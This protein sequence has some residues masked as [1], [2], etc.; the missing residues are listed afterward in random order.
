M[1]RKQVEL[2]LGT[3]A[4][5]PTVQR[6]GQ[7][8]VAVQ[9]TPKTNS[10]LQL[11]QALRYTPQVLGQANN[12][13]KSMG[14]EAA[15]QVADVEAALQDEEVKGI[16]GYDKAYQQGLVKR[17]FS[18]NESAIR[19]RFMDLASSPEYMAMDPNEFVAAMQAERAK[20]TGELMDDFGGNANREDT[21]TA[22]SN[23]F[24][25]GLIDDA[26]VK[27]LENKNNEV[28]INASAEAQKVMSNPDKSLSEAMDNLRGELGS[29]GMDFK[30]V[31]AEMR[32]ALQSAVLLAAEEGKFEQADQLVSQAEKYLVT[33]KAS[34]LGSAEGKRLKANLLNTIEQGRRRA[35]RVKE[36]SG[37]DF[38][39]IA[40]VAIGGLNKLSTK[41]NVTPSQKRAIKDAIS[42]LSPNGDIDELYEKVWTGIGFPQQN[43]GSLLQELGVNG[44]DAAREAYYDSAASIAKKLEFIQNTPI[45]PISLTPEYKQ[46]KIEEFKQYALNNTESVTAEDWVKAT[47]QPF[48]PFEELNE[49]SNELEKGDFIRKTNEYTGI[50]SQLSNAASKIEDDAQ[51]SDFSLNE[52]LLDNLQTQ[53]ETQLLDYARSVAD[54]PNALDL[55]LKKHKELSELAVERMTG[56]RMAAETEIDPISESYKEDLEAAPSNVQSRGRER[57]KYKT[58]ER[59][60]KG[61][62]S[63]DSSGPDWKEIKAERKTM[64]ENRHFSQL[65]LSLYRFGFNSY[66]PENI[67]LMKETG[68]DAGDLRLVANQA[69]LGAVGKR[70]EDVLEADTGFNTLTPEQR[71]IR[72]QYQAL[73]I[74]TIADVEQFMRL[75]AS[76][77]NSS[78]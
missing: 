25:D 63:R 30:T 4:L 39:N 52:T 10:A 8:N 21:I 58:L 68:L 62:R 27:W 14:A 53:I 66:S 41:E 35:E 12:I 17:H 65:G 74:E 5:S 6:A 20:F 56:L 26:N 28:T 19:D 51:S 47:N 72:K 77:L 59:K 40:T 11:A 9:A 54:E 34:L 73:G 43:L 36:E 46:K 16:L 33:G 3:P 69:E 71:E 38:S 7:Y 61:R 37:I 45:N 32:N 29:V 2:N 42:F 76:I 31:G 78:R 23:T 13:A 55:T 75:Q 44:S 64:L 22:L 1:A 15:S 49:A 67:E 70:F 57:I 50:K 24:V 18:A 48:R 60:T